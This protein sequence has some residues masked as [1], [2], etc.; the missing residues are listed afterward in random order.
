MFADVA[1]TRTV[2]ERRSLD[3]ICFSARD[4]MF[5]EAVL[6]P[7]GALRVSPR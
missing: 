6:K 4:I 3:D 2:T 7:A 5:C 1:G